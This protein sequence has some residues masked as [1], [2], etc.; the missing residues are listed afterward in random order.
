MKFTGYAVK[1]QEVQFYFYEEE[2]NCSFNGYLFAGDNLIGKTENGFFSLSLEEYKLLKNNLNQNISLFGKLDDCFNENKDMLFDK[3][4]KMPEIDNNFFY[5]ESIF[6]FKANITPNY[7]R[8]KE[9]IGFIQPE[10][11]KSYLSNIELRNNTLEDL[12]SI[13]IYLSNKIQYINN[14]KTAYW[15]LPEQ[16]ITDNKGVCNDYSTTLL[17]LFLAYNHSL[18][19]YNIALSDHLTTFCDIEDSYIYYDQQEKEVE[20]KINHPYNSSEIKSSLIDLN[21]QYFDYYGLSETEKA[22]IAFNDKEY[23]EFKND[24]HFIDW[25]YSL[26]NKDVKTNLL[27]NLEK[28]YNYV[29]KY[30]ISLENNNTES[31]LS[32][33]K[34]APVELPTFKGFMQKNSFLLFLLFIALVVLVIIL[35]KINK[36]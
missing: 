26:I 31:D 25:Q 2:N 29:K 4:W 7:P 36:K 30:K 23:I 34:P 27:L 10:K 3:S 19:C 35:I 21:K 17:S 32:S 8:S 12:S 33:A 14:S 9:L 1:Q 16:T 20:I 28:Q 6:N 11:L 18:K 15:Q 13:N 5:G 22:K 24:E